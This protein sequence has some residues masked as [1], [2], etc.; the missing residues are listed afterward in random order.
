[1]TQCFLTARPCVLAPTLPRRDSLAGLAR[2]VV[3]RRPAWLH[4]H[5]AIPAAGRAAPHARA[6]A[7]A[8]A[9]ER[10]AW[11]GAVSRRAHL[12]PVALDQVHVERRAVGQDLAAAAHGAQDVG[13]HGPGQLAHRRLD[14]LSGRRL[15]TRGLQSRRRGPRPAAPQPSRGSPRARGGGGGSPRGRRDGRGARGQRRGP[16][17]RRLRGRHGSRT[18]EGPKEQAPPPASATSGRGRGLQVH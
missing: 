12:Q 17:R 14:Q 13:P 16:R 4:T 2:Y 7:R 18:A 15:R 6:R 5:R 9:P 8:R 3:G 11:G 1:M 10:Q